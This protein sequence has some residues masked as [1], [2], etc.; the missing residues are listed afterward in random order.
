MKNFLM[1][2]LSAVM[3]SA[4][5]SCSD[6]AYSKRG[7]DYSQY[8]SLGDALRSDGRLFVDGYANNFIV[9]LKAN[10]NSINNI[11]YAG[12]TT[13]LFVLNNKILGYDYQSVASQVLPSDILRIKVLNGSEA[14]MAY[15]DQGSGGVVEVVTKD[16]SAK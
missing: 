9:K 14:I 13:V 2:L 1:I 15:G 3:I 16:T 12:K 7:K 5:T 8:L 10:R 4:A 11:G 6:V